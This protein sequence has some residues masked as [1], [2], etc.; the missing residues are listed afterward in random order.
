M[1]TGFLSGIA[2]RTET[3]EYIVAGGMKSWL[4]PGSG[5]AGKQPEVACHRRIGRN[6]AAISPH[7]GPH[8]P[9][10]I[11]PLA[12]ELVNRTYSD[13]QWDADNLAVMVRSESR[14]GACRLCRARR[15]RYAK[16]NAVEKVESNFYR[17]GLLEADWPDPPEFLRHNL[18]LIQRLEERQARLRQP[19]MLRDDDDRLDFYAQRIPADICDGTP[20]RAGFASIRQRPAAYS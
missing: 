15:V 11:E 12:G 5:L 2:Q 16:I 10:W 4:W 3:G 9:A 6:D 13:P 14:C 8:D 17:G 7:G 20:C 19:A 1:L 18:D